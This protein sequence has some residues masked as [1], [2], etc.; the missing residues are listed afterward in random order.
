MYINNKKIRVYYNGKRQRDMYQTE[1]KITL[2]ILYARSFIFKLA[3]F[4]AVI[5]SGGYILSVAF[6]DTMHYKTISD[7]H[8]Q[9]E[10]Q[11]TRKEIKDK[12]QSQ[13]DI[14]VTSINDCE[15]A[16]RTE[17]DALITFDPHKTNKKVEAPSLGTFQY[18]ITTVQYYVKKLYNRDIS[19]KEATLLALDDKR[20]RELTE[21]IL[22]NPTQDTKKELGN[23]Y[24]CT[25]K[26]KL[27]DNVNII[28]ELKA[29]L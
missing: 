8:A 2:F 13:K 4:S 28:N 23:W 7:T 21:A 18:K 24:N 10:E 29:L 3:L 6:E 22:F 17:D 5:V 11:K 25:N 14:I 16:G 19:R 12:I 1:S 15:R 26:H 27:K 20:A 9:E